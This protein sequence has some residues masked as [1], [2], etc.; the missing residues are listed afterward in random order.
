MLRTAVLIFAL[1]SQAFSAGPKVT[2]VV[3]D[4]APALEQRAAEQLS[5]DLRALFGAETSIASKL[6]AGDVQALLI[7]SPK[8]NAAIPASEF[9]SVSDQ[10]QVLKSTHSGL[11][12][13]GGSPVATLWAASELSYRFGVRH[14]LQRDFMP[15]EK[16][17]FKLDGFNAVMEPS[18]KGRAWDAFNDQPH[19]CNSWTLEDHARLIPQLARLKFTHL[20]VPAKAANFAPI[21]VDG[22]T[23]GR[24]A[25]KGAKTFAAPQ[26]AG[27]NE[28]VEKLAADY[29]LQVVHQVP[30]GFQVISLGARK[31]SVLPQFAPA[32]LEA[33]FKS[34][35]A[36]KSGGF[37]AGVVMTGD[38][39]AAAHY[40]SRASFAADI[41]AEQA[42]AELV[43]PICG[44]GVSERLWKGF[45]QVEQAAKLIEANDPDLG[46]PGPQMFLRHLD[47][48]TPAPA[49]LTEVKTLY[50]GAMSEMYRANTR[51]RGGARPFILYHAKRMEFALHCC[52]TFESLHKPAAEAAELAPEAIYNA[53]NAYADVARDGSD[54]AVIALLN[55]YGYH[56]VLKALSE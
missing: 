54:R 45:Q 33:D 49:W 34:M 17:E 2:L 10:G 27:L 50:T 22:D 55:I 42:L 16:P 47:P 44:E 53:L 29:G 56:P 30:A 18:V 14:L 11:I 9:P 35:L 46:V 52:T 31:P 1:A 6:P 12:V 4:H 48:K 32:L 8:T 37:A 40:V 51:A 38:L 19:S 28:A 24:S 41:T 3:G 23:A 36:A 5:A 15:I 26:D 21:S 43:T 20:I 7:G 39:N 25:F 13:G